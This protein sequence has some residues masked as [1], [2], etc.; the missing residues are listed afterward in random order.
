LLVDDEESI[1]ELEKQ[2]LERI[3]YRVTSRVNS[4]EALE[5]FKVKSSSFDLVITDM[6]MPYL[7]GAQLAEALL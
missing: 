5:A 1:V 6:N 7:T 4:L 3:G 2:I